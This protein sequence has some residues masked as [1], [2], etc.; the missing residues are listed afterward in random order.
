[1]LL[2]A[3]ILTDPVRGLQASIPLNY[4]RLVI[5]SPIAR[6]CGVPSRAK[7]LSLS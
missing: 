3:R 6:G 4:A 2:V 5:R 7:L 1:M